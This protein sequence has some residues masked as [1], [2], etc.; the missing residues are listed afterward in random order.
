MKQLIMIGVS[1]LLLG[2]T[3][4]K[5]DEFVIKGHIGSYPKDILICAYEHNGNFVLDTIRVKNGKLS[6]RKQLQ[7]PIVANL[8]SRDLVYRT[9]KRDYS[10]RERDDVYGTRYSIGNRYGQSP[11]ARIDMERRN[12]EQ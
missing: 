6:Y 9:K 11:L 1:A 5:K 8:V 4:V 2:C 3:S 7:E 12:A 10:G